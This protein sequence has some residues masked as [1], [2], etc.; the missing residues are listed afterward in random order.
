[1][2]LF[3]RNEKM[4]GMMQK[5]LHPHKNERN[6]RINQSVILL[7]SSAEGPP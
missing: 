3:A 2:A 4:M 6:E 7:L 5:M 1:L